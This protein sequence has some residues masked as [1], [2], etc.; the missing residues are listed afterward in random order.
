MLQSFGGSEMQ[1]K[2]NKFLDYGKDLHEEK[3]AVEQETRSISSCGRFL[4]RQLA[5]NYRL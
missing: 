3:C 2:A 1:F 5:W 4:L